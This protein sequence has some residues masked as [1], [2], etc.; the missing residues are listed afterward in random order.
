MGTVVDKF[1]DDGRI[2]VRW[3]N[4]NTNSYRMGKENKYD[5]KL[6]QTS[7]AGNVTDDEEDDTNSKDSEGLFHYYSTIIFTLGINM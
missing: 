4:G 6:A 3:D 7:L 5:L 2:R 1:E